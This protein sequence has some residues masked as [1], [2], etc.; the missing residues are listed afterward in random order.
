MEACAGRYGKE[1]QEGTGFK[2]ER[3]Q[4]GT[5]SRRKGFKE[6]I[7][8]GTGSR[9]NGF[10][11][12]RAQDGTGPRAQQRDDPVKGECWSSGRLLKRCNYACTV[13]TE[14]GP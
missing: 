6:R 11:T 5:G 8:D 3:V 1:K 7:Q 13:Y 12:E 4:D 10:K 14:R 2:A 9:R